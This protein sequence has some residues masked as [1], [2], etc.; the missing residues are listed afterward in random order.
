MSQQVYNFDIFFFLALAAFFCF[1]PSIQANSSVLSPCRYPSRVCS[2]SP[3]HFIFLTPVSFAVLTKI[4]KVII[5]TPQTSNET[6]LKT[7]FFSRFHCP[8]QTCLHRLPPTAPEFKLSC[9]PQLA[10]ISTT[11]KMPSAHWHT[12]PSR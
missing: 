12:F 5:S 1:P 3:F 6:P 10:R 9:T 7:V 2:F 11:S 4:R 8:C